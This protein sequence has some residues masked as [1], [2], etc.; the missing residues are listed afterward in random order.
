MISSKKILYFLTCAF[1]VS[2][3]V[4]TYADER[5]LAHFLNYVIVSGGSFVL[6]YV[7][8][9]KDSKKSKH[10]KKSKNLLPSIFLKSIAISSIFS[11]ATSELINSDRKKWGVKRFI[12][13]L[14]ASG[15][16]AF[17]S[18]LGMGAGGAI[19]LVTTQGFVDG[20]MV[21]GLI[22][23]GIG[24]GVGGSFADKNSSNK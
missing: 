12:S 11:I 14:T 19:G 10:S 13:N 18:V 2:M 6:S 15:G 8:L 23:A 3:S 22:G 7:L 1:L 17:G 9:P 5:R 4:P 20:I 21:G 16:A 24:A